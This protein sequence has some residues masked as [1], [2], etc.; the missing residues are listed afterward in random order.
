MSHDKNQEEFIQP[1]VAK[2][3]K[4][5]LIKS[6]LDVTHSNKRDRANHLFKQQLRLYISDKITKGS[7]YKVD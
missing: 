7:G 3:L 2:F 5:Q 4:V 6:I 1:L